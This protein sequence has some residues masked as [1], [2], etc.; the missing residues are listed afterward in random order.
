MRAINRILLFLFV[1]LYLSSCTGTREKKGDI[2]P[3]L[4]PQP[5][6]LVWKDSLYLELPKPFLAS[7]PQDNDFTRTLLDGLNT[8]LERLD[9]PTLSFEEKAP[10]GA[11]VTTIDDINYSP[12]EYVLQVTK[13]E[14]VSIIAGGIEGI[15]YG[16]QTLRQLLTS[17]GIPSVIIHDKPRFSY[18]GHMLDESRHLIGEKYLY[19]LINKMQYYKLNRLHWHLVDAGGWRI[20]IKKYPE[21]TEKTAYRTESDWHKWWIQNDRQYISIDSLE[22][23]KE[24]YGGY[25]TQDEVRRIVK[26]ASDHGVTII[27]EIEVPGHSEE[28]LHALPHL[29]CSG[30]ALPGEGDLCV[31]NPD[32][33][34]FLHQVMDEVLALFPS[35]YI[36]FGGDEAGKQAWKSCSKC[37]TLMKDRGMKKIDELQSYIIRDINNYLL[38]KGRKGIGW[39]EILEGQGVPTATVMSWRGVEGGLRAANM[40]Q[41]VIMSPNSHFYLDYY[42]EN[43]ITAPQKAIG[44]YLTLAQSYSYDP[45]PQKATKAER[46]N[47]LG[48]QA[49]LWT[50]YITSPDYAAYMTFPRLL[51]LSEVGW[52]MPEEKDWCSFQ[53][54]V[55][56]HINDLHTDG[57][58]A[59]TL[60]NNLS[61]ESLVDHSKKE[62]LIQLI[63]EHPKDKV[64]YTT[65]GSIPTIKSKEYIKGDTIIVRDS[66][67]LVAAAFRNDSIVGS[68]L[69]QRFDYHKGIG[70]K[71]VWEHPIRGGYPAGGIDTAL[72]DG[73]RG[74]FTYMDKK[75]LGNI[76]TKKNRAVIDLGNATRITHISTRCM[77][78]LDAWVHMPRTVSL[79]VSR[80]GNSYQLV[81]VVNAKTDPEDNRTRIETFDF[82]PNTTSRYIRMTYEMG[83]SQQ[84]LFT[85]EI[86]IW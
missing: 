52:T 75:W 40:G 7:F 29:S 57:L 54:R 32:T 83:G 86:V 68:P 71:V 66:A 55:I 39:D 12:S 24:A 10:V 69:K 3:S 59:Y 46:E 1:S 4:I 63:P 50:E 44:G 14:G 49:N 17:K 45:I 36:H 60:N 15:G 19:K 82:Y 37:K 28:V 43:P 58:P 42:Q 25:Y 78:L 48:V 51:A 61:F 35:Q 8:S 47:I 38:N 73:I 2:L 21:L 77:H 22:K 31:G 11:V 33:Y 41:K 76:G 72:L 9:L 70:K 56:Q 13:A 79:E 20:E 62:I 16:I 27:P 64:F 53:N 85:D 30:K 23:H 5:Q 74:T 84:F 34:L 80:D 6:S 67:L 81:G 65:D 18:R 26:Y